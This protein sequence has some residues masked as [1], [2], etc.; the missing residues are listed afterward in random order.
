MQGVTKQMD[1]VDANISD[2]WASFYKY[3]RNTHSV[4]KS[5]VPLYEYMVKKV[6]SASSEMKQRIGQRE[7]N[8]SLHQCDSCLLQQ[9]LSGYISPGTKVEIIYLIVE[10]MRKKPYAGVICLHCTKKCV[11]SL[12]N[13]SQ[14]KP[15]HQR[16]WKQA[17]VFWLTC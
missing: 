17:A 8:D 16:I 14:E 3:F 5:T 12:W 7:I 13:S 4:V 15:K 2:K 1:S 11:A 10:E 6:K 9:T